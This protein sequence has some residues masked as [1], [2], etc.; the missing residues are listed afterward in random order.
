PGFRA[1][2]G[3][4]HLRRRVRCRAAHRRRRRIARAA[5]G[6][7]NPSRVHRRRRRE[8][9]RQRR[10]Q[11]HGQPRQG[12]RGPGR[13]KSQPRL[14]FRR[15]RGAP[16]AGRLRVNSR[17][18][19][20]RYTLATYNHLRFPIELVRG[21]GSWVE[22][23]R[24]E[25]YLDLYGGHAVCQIGHSHPRWVEDMRRQLDE[26]VFYSNTVYCDLRGRAAEALVTR[27]YPSMVGAYFSCSGADANETALKIARKATGRSYIVAMDKGFHGRTIGALSAT[28]Y[29]KMRDAFPENV[30]QWSRFVPFGDLAAIEALD[31]AEIAAIILEPV[32]SVAGVYVAPPS[33]YRALREHCDRHGICLIFDEVQ[34]GSGR[35]G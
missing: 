18:R 11:R 14:R 2:R 4:P 35:T 30:A 20:D 28:G 17:E 7:G 8:R 10:L 15:D 25:R 27:S 13:A 34:T 19:E 32:Q 5:L 24:G 26:L 22:D 21:R 1:C 12:S 9:A 3:A 16:V 31:P 29:A 33:Y 23:D 6:A